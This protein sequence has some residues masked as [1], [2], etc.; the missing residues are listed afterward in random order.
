MNSTAKDTLQGTAWEGLAVLC[1]RQRLRIVQE[2]AN[3]E[4]C[5]A[6]LSAT[7]GIRQ[8]TLSH[9]IKMLRDYDLIRVRRDADDQ[10]WLYYRINDAKLRR[11]GHT[12]TRLA[13]SAKSADEVGGQSKAE[14]T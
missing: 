11:L 7:L 8:N 1:E 4:R 13:D 2:L 14:A 12:L 3:G 9:H 10:R 6:E 5:A